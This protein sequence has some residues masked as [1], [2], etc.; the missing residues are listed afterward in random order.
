MKHTN[1]ELKQMQSLPLE[2]KIRMTERRILE[3][4]RDAAVSFSGGKDSTVLLHIVRSVFPE[5]KAVFCDTGLEFPEIRDFVKQTQNVDWVKPKAN[6]KQVVDKYG[7]PVVSKIVSQGV[8]ALRRGADPYLYL[9]RKGGKVYLAKKWRRLLDAPFKI[10]DKCCYHL[11]KSPMEAYRKAHG[12]TGTIVGTMAADSRLREFSYLMHGCFSGRGSDRKLAPLSFWLESDIW[13][14]IHRNGLPI[15]KI[16]SMGYKR[17]GCCFCPMGDSQKFLRLK[18][19]HPAIHDYC[20]NRLG[21][22]EVL[23]YVGVPY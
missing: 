22:G 16:Y 14:Y 21:L 18:E 23:D 11:K 3:F 9:E 13:D 7:F 19:T 10:S 2:C 8:A 20:I 17:T 4:G 1:D 6:F 15:S 12:I 5:I